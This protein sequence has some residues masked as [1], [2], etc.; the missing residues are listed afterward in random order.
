MWHLSAALR[1]RCRQRPAQSICLTA[2]H[3]E[4]ATK[5]RAV[6]RERSVHIRPVD[7]HVFKLSLRSLSL[8]A[9]RAALDSR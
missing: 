4:G 9:S 2:S 5:I 8:D 6:H 7:S 1:N 3:A